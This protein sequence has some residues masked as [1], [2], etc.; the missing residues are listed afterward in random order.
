MSD[1]DVRW[2]CAFWFVIGLGAGVVFTSGVLV[3]SMRKELRQE[4]VNAGAARWEVSVEGEVV[5]RWLPGRP[6]EEEAEND[7]TE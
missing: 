4:A 6:E 5:F 2:F 7:G 3:P 1:A